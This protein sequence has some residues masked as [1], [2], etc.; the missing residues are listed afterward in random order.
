MQEIIDRNSRL[1]KLEENFQIFRENVLAS[2]SSLSAQIQAIEKNINKTEICSDHNCQASS[3]LVP[4]CLE[5]EEQVLNYCLLTPAEKRIPLDLDEEEFF[6]IINKKILHYL[7]VYA[8]FAPDD[9][10][11][12]SFF[13][14]LFNKE[15]PPEVRRKISKIIRLK[16]IKNIEP[17]IDIVKERAIFRKLIATAHLFPGSQF[18]KKENKNEIE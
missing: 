2:L 8:P 6:N 10:D 3:S 15:L 12:C 4:Y 16:Y 9:K 13:T 11:I 7:K 1:L 5:S 17:Y 14:F 18:L